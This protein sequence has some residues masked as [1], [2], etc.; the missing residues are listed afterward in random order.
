M[1]LRIAYI[2]EAFSAFPFSMHLF[3]PLSPLSSLD[4]V[5][6]TLCSQAD[7]IIKVNTKHGFLSHT[8]ISSIFLLHSD[9]LWFIFFFSMKAKPLKEILRFSATH[10]VEAENVGY[11]YLDVQIQ[12]L[13]LDVCLCAV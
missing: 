4:V 3:Y 6:K 13:S 10:C 7:T 5:S 2:T 8:Y 12:S 9:V 11:L 1:W